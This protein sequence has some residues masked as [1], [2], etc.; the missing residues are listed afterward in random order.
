MEKAEKYKIVIM[1][2]ILSLISFVIILINGSTYELKL[3]INDN[4]KNIKDIKISVDSD[5]NAVKLEEKNF[6]NGVLNL[7]FKSLNKGIAFVEVVSK[8][9]YSI[10]KLFVHNFGIITLNRRLGKC[11]GDIVVPISILILILE[12][13]IIAIKHYKRNVKNSLYQYKNIS[14]LGSIIFLSFMFVN[15]LIQITNY[16]GLAYSIELIIKS[17]DVFS[18]NV[19]PLFAITLILVTI[20]NFKLLRKEGISWKNMLG[21]ILSISFMLLTLIP[22]LM[23][24]FFKNSMIIHFDDVKSLAYYIYTFMELFIYSI[25]SY[26]ESILFATIVLAYKA[27]KKIPKFDKDYIIILGC[28]IKKDGSLTPILKNRADR[29]IEFSKMQKEATGKDIIFVPSGGKG[30]NE[31]ISEAEAIKNYLIKQ[32]ISEDKIIVED[33]SKNTYQNIKFS[34][35]LIKQKN[36][37][38]NVAFSTTNYHTFRAGIIATKQKVKIEGIGSKTKSYFW[39]NAFIRE[40]IA[41]LYS[42]KK[43][44]Y[45]VI[46]LIIVTVL[47][48]VA[49]TFLK[50]I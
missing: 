46:L 19:L 16:K 10:N 31:I 20:S 6:K 29:A 30:H 21:I 47:I 34:N 40:F 38:S 11:S 28:M 4:I 2:F 39:I 7:K 45:K 48:I 33:K 26:L 36:S 32:G 14:Y 9:H 42:E 3:D 12:L 43:N 22:N 37:N 23:N 18:K 13:L 35:E 8:E 44:I 27:A 15:Q 1:T 50:N 25:V 17:V 5:Q 41:T 24:S 49:L